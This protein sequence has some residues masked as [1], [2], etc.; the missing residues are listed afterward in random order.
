MRRLMMVMGVTLVFLAAM[1]GSAQQG[2]APWAGTNARNIQF[3][4]IDTSRAMRPTA[5]DKAFRPYS[6]PRTSPLDR[7]FPKLNI[8]TWPPKVANV[9]VVDQKSNPYQPNPPKGINPFAA[10]NKKK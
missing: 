7:L 3:K 9:F 5:A 8:A 2:S 10:A 1:K 6:Q 4:P